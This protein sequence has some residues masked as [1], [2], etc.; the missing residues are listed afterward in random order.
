MLKFARNKKDGM[1]RNEF[2]EL[3][4]YV[5]LGADANLAD[6]LFYIFDDDNS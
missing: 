1:N 3:L 2:G 5:G 4:S 6:K